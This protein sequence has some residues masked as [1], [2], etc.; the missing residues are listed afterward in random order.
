MQCA[1]STA[2]KHI[3]AACKLF[4]NL[5]KHG[6]EGKSTEQKL[7]ILFI[8]LVAFRRSICRQNTKFYMATETTIC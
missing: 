4:Q 1:S 3:P 7:H 5:D 6:G 2:S 8:L